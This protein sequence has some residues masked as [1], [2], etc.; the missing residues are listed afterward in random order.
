MQLTQRRLIAAGVTL[1]PLGM[2]VALFLAG[3]SQRHPQWWQPSVQLAVLGGITIMIY[4]VNV[5]ALPTHSGKPWRSLHLVALQLLS[6]TAGA[7]L[8]AWGYGYRNADLIKVGHALAFVGACL[9]L[10]NLF[11][12]FLQPGAR[13]PKIPWAERKMQQKIDR[14]AI[15]FTMISGMMV[16]IGTGVG[17]ILNWW[18]PEQGRWDLVWGHLMLL[19]FFFAMA[20]GTSYHMLARWA[21]FDFASIRVVAVHLIAYLLSLPAM[22]IALGWDVEWLFFIGGPLMAVS[23]F[24]WAASLLPVAWRLE[25]AVRVGITLAMIFMAAG[26]VLGVL[27]AIDP[28]YGPRLR[29]TH[30]MANL[31]G[32]SG[33]LIS[34]F[35]YR[36]VPELAGT[37]GMRWPQWKMP[38]LM[39]M[40]LG[41]GIGMVFMGLRMYGHIEPD[42]V[43]WPCALGAVG[44]LIFAV[45]TAVTFALEPRQP[46]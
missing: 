20:S 43:L 13:P 30:V 9:F 12:L 37:Q 31:F 42:V 27:F 34:G 23:M 41:C 11:L 14:L 36:Y 26:V 29:S 33:L 24:A 19:G 21:G 15:P 2:A 17:L 35:G 22:V 7:W 3:Y 18:R 46:A 45:N 4:G 39:L 28:A 10:I 40:L 16:V 8:A 1:G 5:E 32:F 44:M 25:P 6:G 38:Q